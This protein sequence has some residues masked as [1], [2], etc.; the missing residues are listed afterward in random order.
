MEVEYMTTVVV[1]M[2]VIH[3]ATLEDSGT[4]TCIASKRTQKKE[5]TKEIQIKGKSIYICNL[6]C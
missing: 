2:L 6:Y 5:T 4:Y 3:S 1:S